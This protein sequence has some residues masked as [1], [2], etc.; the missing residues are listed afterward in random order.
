MLRLN[1]VSSRIRILVF[2]AFLIT[3]SYTFT[4]IFSSERSSLSSSSSSNSN[5]NSLGNIVSNAVKNNQPFGKSGVDNVVS[6]TS[7][8]NS[9]EYQRENA[10]FVTLCRNSDLWQMMNAIKRIEDRFNRKFKYDWVFLN[11]EEFSDQ[12]KRLTSSL[13]SGT[14]KYGVISSDH[15]SYPDFIDQEKAKKSRQEM[16][17]KGIIYAGLESYRHMC[18]FNSG[19]F[20]KHPLMLPYKYY[21]RV[22]PDINIFCDVDYDLFKYMRENNK[23]YGFT[24]SIYEFRATIETLWSTTKEFLSK[25]P[26]FVAQN[27]LMNFI[28]DDKGNE[29]NLCHF[30][31][32]FEI[33]DMDFW[34]SEAYEKYFQYLD[35]S[36]GFFYERWGDA[37][38]HSIAAALFLSKDK[39]HF[40]DDVGYNHGVYSMCPIDENLRMEKKCYCDPEQDFTF[41]GYSCGKRYYDV[42]NLKK[43]DNWE[44][45]T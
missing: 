31:S 35:N 6:D 18:R 12:F 19:F 38:V 41:R 29:Y 33:A 9:N 25:Y 10:T 8:T 1:S 16:E 23:T 34:R 42:M 44:K 22:E 39:I 2:A 5:S 11:N 3:I 24:I 30:W 27:N 26:K 45:Y 17:K 20:Y 21:W 28:S 40:F 32:N 7:L 15:W 36:G 43:P 37:P 4:S 14:A 13:I